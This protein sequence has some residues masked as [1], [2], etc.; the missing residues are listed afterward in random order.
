MSQVEKDEG[1]VITKY[2]GAPCIDFQNRKDIN[3]KAGVIQMEL[4]VYKN[5]SMSVSCFD[6]S[7][8]SRKHQEGYVRTFYYICN[9]FVSI[10]VLQ[11]EKSIF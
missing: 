10:N 3:G 4:Q 2:N 7:N 11:N 1:D 8:N 6:Q 5:V 9:F